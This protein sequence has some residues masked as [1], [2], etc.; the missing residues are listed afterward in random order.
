VEFCVRVFPDEEIVIRKKQKP[1]ACEPRRETV[2]HPNCKPRTHMRSS[3]FKVY[4]FAMGVSGA[5]KQEIYLGLGKVGEWTKMSDNKTIRKAIDWLVGN[6]WLVEVK[7]PR[8]GIGGEGRYLVVMHDAWV[9]KHGSQGCIQ[10][11]AK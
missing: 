3:A 1:E 4:D 5:G 2:A 8:K 7:K 11:P 6:G 9:A 10:Q